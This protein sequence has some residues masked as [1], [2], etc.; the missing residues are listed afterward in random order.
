[1]RKTTMFL[2]LIVALLTQ[3][4]YAQL[5]GIK[6][7][8][9]DYATIAAAVTALNTA[10]VGAGGVTFNV[11]SAHTEM[12]TEP[13]LLTATG[14]S[15]NPIVFQKSGVGANPVLM[16]TDAGTL[17]TTTL[18]G[19]GD[20]V[21]II[22][23][24]DYV[25]FD[26]FDIGANDQG[27]EYG[28]YLRKASVTDGCKFVT[29]KN[30]IIVM[31][32]GTSALVVG[33]YSS[34]NDAAS[35]VSSATGIT[36]TS[37]DGRNENVTLTGNRIENVFAGIL[38][39]GYGHTSAPYDFY[40]Q[41]YVIGATGAGNTIQNFAGNAASTSYGVYLIY[42]NN[43]SVSY[44]T[45][46][47]TAAGGS[48]ATA[49][50][51]GMFHSTGVLSSF[52]AS[53]NDIDLTTSGT[54]NAIYGINNASTGNL[55]VDNNTI[56]LNNT[57]TT[58]GV[59]GYI[60][61]SSAAA[62]TAVSISNNKFIGSSLLTSSGSLYLIYNN[63]S[64]ATPGVTNVTGNSLEGVLNRTATTGATY[65]Y[66]NNGSPT[67]T[68]NIFNNVFDSIYV[69][70]TTGAVYGL[71]S[72]TG[73]AHTHHFYN[74]IISDFTVA[75]TGTVYGI[76]RT[77]A[78]GSVYGNTVKNLTSGG[79]MWGLSNGSGNVHIYKNSVYNLTSNSTGST[80]GLV[81]GIYFSS[82]TND[83]AYN[84]FISDLK[85]PA[86]SGNDVIRGIN[87]I[88]TAA[89]T[90][91]GLYYNTIYLN[92]SSTGADFGTSGIYHTYSA[93]ATSAALDMRNN[94][95][96]NTSTAA[97]TGLTVAF[98]RSAATSLLNYNTLSNNNDLY[99]GVPGAAN[100]IYYD[101]TN[102]DQTLNEFKTRVAPRESNSVSEMPTFIDIAAAPYNLHLNTTVA[103][104]LESGATPVSAP[105]AVTTDY[106][107]DSRN[108]N[109][110]DIGADEF[111]GVLLDLT[112][113]TIVYTPLLN[114]VTTTARSLVVDVTDASGVPTTAPGW[115]YLYWKK[116]V[117]GAFVGVAP[118]SVTGSDYT[119]NFGAGTTSGDT[120]FYYVVAQDA[121]TSH[122][123]GAF[124]SA[125]AGG[126]TSNPPAAST[127]PTTPS[128]YLITPAS[129]TGT[130]TVGL[131]MFNSVAGKNITF[132]PVTER[133]K[134]EVIIEVPSTLTSDKANPQFDN[135][136][137][138]S[139]I[140][141]G[142]V[143]LIDVDETRWIAMENGNVYDGPLFI[144][145]SD[146]PNLQLP[147]GVEGVYATITEALTDLNLRGVSGATTFSLVDATYPTETY[148]LT[149]SIGNENL[150]SS[151]NTV[152]IKPASGVTAVV[153][154]ASASG[155]VF[156]IR[157]S[158]VTIDGS[159]AGGTDRS[160]T[161]E[162]T[163]TTSPQVVNIA[164]VGTTPITNVT[165]QNS[166][167]INGA[168]TSSALV[169][170]A[171]DGT[172]GYFNDLKIQN[173]NIQKAYIATY[174]L[175]VVA[176][177]NGSG[178]L[179]TGN[180]I[181]ATGAN[182][183][184]LV[185][186]Y[187][188]G[189]DGVT[190]SNN[191]VSNLSTTAAEV[192]RGIWL[193]TGTVNATVSGNTVS[194][195]FANNTGAATAIGIAVSSG[196]VNA[197][198]SVTGNT[199]SGLTTTGTGTTTG[200]YVF[201][202]TEGVVVQENS[203]TNIKNT[204]ATGWGA[205]GIWL[206]STSATANVSAYNNIIS[207][208]T[209]IGYAGVGVGDNGYGIVVGAGAGYKV[210][211]NS[212]NLFT[213]QTTLTGRPGS[214]NILSTVTAANAV[215]LRNNIFN[216]SQTVGDNRYSIICAAAAT[217]FSSINYNDYYTTGP[218]IGYFGS[219]PVLDLAAWQVLSLG[220][221]NSKAVDP[222]FTDTLNLRPLMGSPV[223]FAGTP[224]EGVTTDYLGS[225]RTNTPSMG[226]YEFPIANIG[227]ANLQ[228]PG[229]ATITLG[230]SV[231]VYG[232]IW[233][234]GI[235]NSP[236]AGFGIQA[237]VGYSTENSNPDTWTNWVAST[238]NVDAGNNDEYQA[239]IGSN[240]AAG[241][242]YYAT[243]YQVYDG[244]YYYGG[245]SGGE[246]NGTT[247]VSGVL[248]VQAPLVLDWQRSAAGENLP[249]W[250]SST[251]NSERGFGWGMVNLPPSE[252]M[253]GRVIV[254]TRNG[255]TYVKLLNDST[256]ADVGE[257]DV[258]DISLGTFVVNDADV[259][260]LGRIYVANMV[261]SAATVPFKVYRWDNTASA[262][263]L[264]LS[265]LGDAV[266]LGD[267]FTVAYDAASEGY[268][269]WAAS[270]TTGQAK[271]YKWTQIV[272]SDSLNQVPTVITLSD[273]ITTGIS[274]ASVGPLPNGDFYW[275]A[276]GQS[277][278]KYQANG[279]LVGVVPGTV[280]AT[281][282]GAIKFLGTQ[283]TSEYFATFQYGAGNQ[284]AR[285]VEVPNGDPTTAVTYGVTTPLG[286]NANANGL[287]DVAVKHNF[288]GSKTIFVLGT[289]NGLGAYKSTQVIPVELAAFS[290]E[291]QDRN[292]MLQW[293]TS[294]ETNSASFEVERTISGTNSWSAVGSVRAAGTTVETKSYSYLDKGLNS[295]KY[296][297]RLKQIDL[298]GSYSYS[299]VVE[300]EVGLPVTFGMSQNYPNPFNPTTRIEY[301][302]PA[303]ARVTLELYDITGQRVASLVNTEM[304]AG[305][306]TFDL[307]VGSYGLASGVY[308]YRMTAVEKT[309]GKNFVNTKKM[310]MLK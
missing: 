264:V 115:P 79:N 189:L 162:N 59:H 271:V 90:N 20:A 141:S 101:A 87:S 278:R 230:G 138:I 304:T 86:A 248:T 253:A 300:V 194:N 109:T 274:A 44:N 286:T 210:Y 76:H 146:Y 243:R 168:S 276:N 290:A 251:G 183:S 166:N 4:N 112:P 182:A 130:Y 89:T 164:S 51:Y 171:S 184:R 212:V 70:A 175:T 222:Q 49:I 145:K 190:I 177:G 234:D 58:S 82:L 71:L 179:V 67:G 238:F 125:G 143:E 73:S 129:L 43:A 306:Y 202:T 124:P 150:T 96:V 149:I 221:T 249:V 107:G 16:R 240:L 27:I 36:V 233:V 148:P 181:N 250:F 134:K 108:A 10:G 218:N 2:F 231:T 151:T 15:D 28:Y 91:L 163:S 282:S 178:T 232:Q 283:G 68:E 7:I 268:A 215:D 223:I 208:V 159:N 63:S 191:D 302:V 173:N 39:R 236:G 220:D 64:Q 197:N 56:K 3:M 161:I 22:E 119:F 72:T 262:P 293:K 54:T 275:N 165:V 147:E 42:H 195:F 241:T 294:T 239:N 289:N 11:A 295:A 60:Y 203:I 105:I 297:Y 252:G 167:L 291:A 169:A 66:Y 97:G 155:P 214:I 33:I 52:T 12:I 100:L 265:Y 292:V 13:I 273:A 298:D 219:A 156:R 135:S 62:S 172:A 192:E 140:V 174:L 242:Y 287:G 245:F 80:N 83:Y 260:H 185:G 121:A 61:N 120:V 30:S 8:P 131:T 269:I 227:W 153:S 55:T 272:G 193:A 34:N 308:I 261:T 77:L 81:S 256:G 19:Q 246:W 102:S 47:N 85:A 111:N 235:T 224:V 69:T 128:S 133:V 17:T 45:I 31:T 110:P 116:G 206:A 301:Q 285:V 50:L 127:P 279:T 307:S 180:E 154:G 160:L 1:M 84:N 122:N 75:S 23:G 303:D 259:D 225:T 21:V 284:N 117:D 198:I 103:T 207:D 277:A 95:V 40:D 88:A 57:V 229:T 270:A 299:S 93:T 157:N 199:V 94:I 48:G 99:A 281:G 118:S 6:T 196:A 104:Q 201:S 123:T 280:V 38:L 41:N 186:I 46:N 188:Q 204:N 53:N 176:P 247:N 14:T 257:L 254:P 74:N 263:K 244:A 26:G 9:G 106:D 126:F 296:Q 309:S 228:W 37:V 205:N 132:T 139:S 65:C 78:S 211:Y 266:R 216:N 98:R 226:A 92:A 305:Y 267:V 170:Y 142:R 29:I 237:W 25:T 258:T 113:P 137:S 255:G 24:S 217:I 114:T 32:K 144:K 136:E 213:N 18:G 35:L 158:Y 209:A 200:I 310:M 5:S 288:D 187:A 152:T